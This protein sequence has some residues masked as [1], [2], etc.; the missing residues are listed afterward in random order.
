MIFVFFFTFTVVLIPA[1][2]DKELEIPIIIRGQ[3]QWE[4]SIHGACRCLQHTVVTTKHID[5]YCVNELFILS[6]RYLALKG[7]GRPNTMFSKIQAG[8]WSVWLLSD[9]EGTVET[10]LLRSFVGVAPITG[11]QVKLV[12]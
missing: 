10:D 7:D 1:E 8:T 5:V 12:S 11:E 2:A 9:V 4:F 3:K 6:A